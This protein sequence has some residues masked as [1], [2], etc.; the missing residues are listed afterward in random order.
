MNFGNVAL[1]LTL[2]GAALFLP[3]KFLLPVPASAVA[4][5]LCFAARGA[6]A[7]YLEQAR[8]VP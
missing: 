7:A 4:I 2:I 1:P 3:L 6:W 8:R 5:A